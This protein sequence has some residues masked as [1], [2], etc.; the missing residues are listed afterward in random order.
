MAEK[1][2]KSL[3]AFE[4]AFAAARKK[5]GG[6][7]GIFT[8]KVG[9]KDKKFTT[10]YEGEKISKKAKEE[11]KEKKAVNSG[12]SIKDL[13]PLGES[14]LL[15][16][17][18]KKVIGDKKPAA[19]KVDVGLS[20]ALR[21][22]KAKDKEILAGKKKAG[23][24]GS[25]A[26]SV[27]VISA[28]DGKKRDLHDT[29]FGKRLKSMVSGISSFIDRRNEAI[30]KDVEKRTAMDSVKDVKSDIQKVMDKNKAYYKK[31][32]ESAT[33]KDL[34]NKT[35]RMIK[36]IIEGKIPMSQEAKEKKIDSLM[37]SAMNVGGL[38]QSSMMN[39]LSRKINPTTGLTMQK[40]GM[41][42]YRKKGMFY[43]GGMARRGK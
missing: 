17:G 39:G 41:I 3:S 10:A 26:V 25:G 42:D 28:S 32:S 21:D 20:K 34:P 8:F 23:M 18:A 15:A 31:L 13:E 16:I 11:K 37:R 5:A 6:P 43:G 29:G 2:K 12:V 30:K 36:N 27:T 19:G 7:D 9:G 35:Q 4:K 24:G 22:L 38:T 40:G 1:K 14:K 33:F